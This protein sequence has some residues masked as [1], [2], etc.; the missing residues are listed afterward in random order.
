[1]RWIHRFKY[2]GTM[3]KPS[4]KVVDSITTTSRMNVLALWTSI[5]TSICQRIRRNDRMKEYLHLRRPSFFFL[6][7]PIL[8]ILIATLITQS[9]FPSSSSFSYKSII[10]TNNSSRIRSKLTQIP[11]AFTSSNN[12]AV[13]SASSTHAPAS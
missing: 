4:R 6:F 9:T 7:H 13:P 10:N 11:A 3:G 2:S 5:S 1:M 12:T 8:L